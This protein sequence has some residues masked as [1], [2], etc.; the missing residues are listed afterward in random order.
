MAPDTDPDGASSSRDAPRS[1]AEGD[2]VWTEASSSPI[3]FEGTG[4]GPPMQA[5]M[6][7]TPSEL[8]SRPGELECVWTPDVEEA[9]QEAVRLYPI[10][11]QRRSM[12]DE[13]GKRYGRNELIARHI[14]YR[15]GK[16]R[17]RKQVSSHVQV[18]ARRETREN[19]VRS[20]A[21]RAIIAES[22][23][24]KP[25]AAR[26]EATTSLEPGLTGVVADANAS[27]SKRD[28]I[29]ELLSSDANPSQAKS[30]LPDAPE[31]ELSAPSASITRASPPYYE[32]ST[33]ISSTSLELNRF[34]MY[35][36]YQATNRTGE[37]DGVGES[38]SCLTT[39][40]HLFSNI[41]PSVHDASWPLEAIQVR[42]V[43]DKFPGGEEGLEDLYY[44]GPPDAFFV[45]KCWMDLNTGN[46]PADRACYRVASIFK[47]PFRDT[48]M[49]STRVCSFGQVVV[50]RLQA[51][52]PSLSKDSL[53][54][55]YT[56]RSTMSECV[57]NFIERLR[58]LPDKD[59]MDSVLENF[60][61]LQVISKEFP[62]K[63]LLCMAYMFEVSRSVHG[64][65]H[66]IYRLSTW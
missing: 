29:G 50:D 48:I 15:T 40:C 19:R 41:K 33:R 56:V 54:Y 9:F 45:I 7:V 31:K 53:H 5:G 35:V 28:P 65:R 59:R 32:Y 4:P 17:T 16:I 2:G 11:G 1:E 66:R 55:T 23:P 64:S 3:P 20:E 38:S 12:V 57:I 10:R 18:L 25:K 39:K 62:R 58:R 44:S 26:L 24:S 8:E 37:G 61:V 22:A 36:L 60:T 46:I 27:T 43:S 13:G 34:S 63:T 42:E 51:V 30:E 6:R 21:L 52:N 14:K 47:S 49:C